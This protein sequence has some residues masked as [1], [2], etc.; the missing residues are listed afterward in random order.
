MT[1]TLACSRS[2]E[3]GTSTWR[4]K[5]ADLLLVYWIHIERLCPNHI[6][7]RSSTLLDRIR[8]MTRGVLNGSS[9]ISVHV[10]E[11][12][13]N[14]AWEDILLSMCFVN[15]EPNDQLPT[16]SGAPRSP[17]AG[18]EHAPRS[19]ESS[20][21]YTARSFYHQ[22]RRLQPQLSGTCASASKCPLVF[23]QQRQPALL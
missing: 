8:L 10:A 9:S 11:E 18:I 2:G 4:S 6:I 23:A 21:R 13:V 16:T 20:R 17:L 12:V 22:A 19:A 15:L 14:L 1:G 3:P 7:K 5:N